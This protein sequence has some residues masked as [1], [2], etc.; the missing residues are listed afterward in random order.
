M[1]LL[2]QQQSYRNRPPSSFIVCR[3]TVNREAT[4]EETVASFHAGPTLP[5]ES[6]N[7]RVK[8][9]GIT[10][11]DNGSSSSYFNGGVNG[12]NGSA[13]HG[14]YGVVEKVPDV[15][16]NGIDEVANGPLPS[17]TNNSDILTMM[18][19]DPNHTANVMTILIG[20]DNGMALKD[21]FWVGFY[22]DKSIGLVVVVGFDDA[23]SG[24]ASLTLAST[25]KLS[26]D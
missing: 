12:V 1:P 21:V 9:N 6:G 23:G 19:T 25:R 4:K 5:T 2:Q 10:V 17:S 16:L 15:N 22:I 26:S 7:G 11:N 18:M 14:V 20:I 13:Q 24:T 8:V 3:S